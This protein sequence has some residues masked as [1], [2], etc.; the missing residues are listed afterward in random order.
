MDNTLYK[1]ALTMINSVGPITAKQIVA[2]CGGPE[3]VFKEK[4]KHLMTIPKIGPKTANEILLKDV[5]IKAEKELRFIEKN[6]IAARFYLDDDYPLRLKHIPDSPIMIFGQGIASLD[7]K[8]M[9]GIVGTRKPT[10]FGKLSCEKLIDELKDYDVSIISGLAYGIDAIAHKKAISASIPT[11]AV[12]GNGLDITYPAV[13]RQL[14]SKMIENGAVISEF[15]SGTTPEREHFPMRNR[16]IAGLS[17]AVVV[18]ESKRKG[19]SMITA[20]FAFGYNKDVFALPGRSIDNMAKGPNFLIK[21]N[22]ASLAESAEDIAYKMLWSKGKATKSK[23]L[24]LFEDLNE[25]EK[26]IFK[27]IDSCGDN[28]PN[29]DQLLNQTSLTKGELSSTLL[30]LECKNL[31]ISLPGSRYSTS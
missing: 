1:V 18:I 12:L 24:Q 17:D 19:G 29:Y 11:I 6:N 2:Y 26:L 25:K 16:I 30:E 22:I 9:V 28:K 23:Q 3:A 13:H 8:R 4:K 20:H 15:P 14:R 27:I 5:L 31:L 21:S 10:E 7:A